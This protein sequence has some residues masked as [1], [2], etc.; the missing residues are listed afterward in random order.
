MQW[1]IRVK[2]ASRFPAGEGKTGAAP[3]PGERGH[4]R[5]GDVT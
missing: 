3:E 1:V 2:P 4:H 5:G